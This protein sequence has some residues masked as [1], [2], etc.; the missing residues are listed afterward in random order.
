M[1]LLAF[2]LAIVA[3]FI[4]LAGNRPGWY[5]RYSWYSHVALG[6]AVLTIAWIV[7]LVTTSHTVNF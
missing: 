2:L 6:L 7:E 1:N 3:V 5:H 4:F